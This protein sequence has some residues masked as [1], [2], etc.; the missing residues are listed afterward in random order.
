[1]NMS[2][3]EVGGCVCVV[4]FFSVVKTNLLRMRT[5][6]SE[7]EIASPKLT[8]KAPENRPFAPKRKG[9]S[10]NRT[11]SRALANMR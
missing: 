11:C 3:L 6:F 8:A 7:I 10:S 1:M 4:V 5:N 2:C 9:F